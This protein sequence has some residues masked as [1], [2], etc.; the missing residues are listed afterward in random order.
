MYFMDNRSLAF[1]GYWKNATN[2]SQDLHRF[3][4]HSKEEDASFKRTL[5]KLGQKQSQSNKHID[6]E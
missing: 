3:R 2:S 1:L 5:I 4:N 6:F